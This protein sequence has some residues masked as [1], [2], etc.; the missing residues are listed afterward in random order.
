MHRPISTTEIDGVWSYLSTIDWSEPWLLGL[1]LFHLVC[2]LLTIS[3]R[4]CGTPLGAYFLVLLLL[5]Y[6]SE[7]INEWAAQNWKLFAHQQ[8]FD[9]NGLFI[10][11]LF[12]TPLLINCLVIVVLW[13]WNAGIMLVQVKQSQIRRDIR[14]AREENSKKDK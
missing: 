11:L 12:S 14:A 1:G 2:A 6:M 9:S 13:L 5:V 3:L 7:N 4:N 8:Y 10:S